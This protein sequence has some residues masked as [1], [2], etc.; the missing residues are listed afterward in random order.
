MLL[1]NIIYLVLYVIAMIGRVPF[2]IKVKKLKVI[3]SIKKPREYSLI[4]VGVPMMVLPLIHIF[5]NWIEV[6]NVVVPLIV[7]I[8]GGVLFAGAVFLHNWTHIELNTNWS[9]MLE[10][11][12]NQKLITTGPYKHIRHPM[13]AAFLLWAISQGFFLANWLVLVGGTLGFLILYFV[14]VKDEEQM[15]LKQFGKEYEKHMNS[16]GRLLPKF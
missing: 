15:M 16:T 7:Q 1:I 12:K 5:S 8:L 9:P 4:L 6:F 13:Y 10:I 2:A 14:R 11:K 3:L